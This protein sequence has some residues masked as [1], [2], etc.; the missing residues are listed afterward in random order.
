MIRKR[1]ILY[2]KLLKKKVVTSREI[3]KAA[4][5]I[6][7]LTLS[8]ALIPKYIYG[9]YTAKLLAEGKLQ[10]IR[11]GLY[12]VLSPFEE[13][14]KHIPDKFIIAGK[15][16]DR[17]YLGFH[18]ALEYYGSAYSHYNE[19]YITVLPEDRFS[20]FKYQNLNFKPVFTKEILF[21]I[22]TKKYR[23][24]ELKVSSKERTLVDCLDR[25]DYAG[26]WEECFKS[27]STLSG[28][29]FWKI[30]DILDMYSKKSLYAKVGFV[31][32]LLREQSVF[33]E[34]LS[35]E[36]LNKIKANKPKTPK[37]FERSVSSTLNKDWN[38]YVPAVFV[39]YL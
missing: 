9:E 22:E 35:D 38:L 8:P 32:E 33:Y 23:T 1:D 34:H 15:I 31:L 16:R 21:D 18:S 12:A 30:I 14:E 36:I 19:M 5:E 39:E 27:L 13:P 24:I 17:Y 6:T 4:L 3:E 28:L 20:P 7:E 29:D 10:R 11:K 25:P 2:K 26:G 37:Y